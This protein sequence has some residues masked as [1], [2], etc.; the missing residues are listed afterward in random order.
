MFNNL[1]IKS[2]ISGTYSVDFIAV[3]SK[4]LSQINDN[5]SIFIID[6]NVLE[7]FSEN[8]MLIKSSSR[9]VIIESGERNKTIEYCQ[10]VIKELIELNVRKDDKLIA[11]GGGVTQDIVA[12]ISS[13][14]FRGVSWVFFPTTLLAQ[15]D[16]CIGSK[17]SINFDSY[18]N[19]LGTFNPPKHIYIYSGFLNTLSE[20]DVRSGIGEMLHY[21]FT[22]GITLAKEI[23]D[24]ISEIISDRSRLG[25]FI[26]SSLNI[27]RKII[28][29]DEFDESIRHIFNYGHT[30]GH[31]L[32]AI[33]NYSISHGQSV[34]LGM[35]LANYISMK[36]E[37]LDPI[38]FQLMHEIL[39]KNTPEFEFTDDNISNYLHALSKD[40]KNKG[41]KIGCILTKGPGKV[42]KKYIDNNDWLRETILEYSN[43]LQTK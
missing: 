39:Q 6:K 23:T 13:I 10:I 26:K 33:T 8:F 27:K 24:Q 16:S 29:I 34:T 17:S 4:Q 30:F 35:D 2:K 43:F 41:D 14:L 21:F 12:F 32:E 28:E 3:L 22:D 36:L 18:K 11:I 25:N 37:L 20:S 19:L 7:L 42:E 15:C 38:S 9:L 1:T 40:K 5:K 31:A